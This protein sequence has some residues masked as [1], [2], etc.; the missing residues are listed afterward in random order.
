MKEFLLNPG[1]SQ[2]IR[3]D[4]ADWTPSR[5]PQKQKI[6]LPGKDKTYLDS[7]VMDAADEKNEKSSASS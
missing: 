1:R 7:L 5:R 6:R 3:Q 2:S 4:L